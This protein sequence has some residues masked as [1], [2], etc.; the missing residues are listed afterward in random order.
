MEWNL[1]YIAITNKPDEAKILDDCGVQQIMVDT[2][3]LGKAERQQGKRTII[4][5]HKIADIVA[6]KKMQL[7]AEIICRVNPFNSN[8][9]NEIDSAIEAGADCIMMPMIKNIDEY[10]AIVD[11]VNSRVKII[12]LIETTY[13]LF[14]LKEIIEYSNLTQIHFGLNDLFID[15]GYKNLFEILFSEFFSN[16]VNFAADNIEVVGIGGIGNP[17]TLLKVDSLLLFSEFLN[18]RGS[19]VI[20]S[21]SFFKDGY[22]CKSITDGL[23]KFEEILEDPKKYRNLVIL[24]EQVK[25]LN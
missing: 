6:L 3:I 25:S 21:R 13:S 22:D 23:S 18:L 1:N 14:V 17:N 9:F 15:I 24:K 4:S 8:I 20:L 12:P 19:S 5:H 10:K 16:F 11:R 2:E 7:K